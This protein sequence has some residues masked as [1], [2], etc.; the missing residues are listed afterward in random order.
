MDNANP[1]FGP[2]PY[3]PAIGISVVKKA[4]ARPAKIID[5]SLNESS[6]GASSLAT[7]KTQERCERLFR[8]PDPAS[9]VLRKAIG[10]AYDLNP[11]YLVCG[12]GSEELLDIIGR[13][14]ARP[15]DE[16]LFSQNSFMQ[17]PIVAMRVGA[18]VVT[19]SEENLTTVVDT[20][21]AKVTDKTKSF[22][23]RTRT[24]RPAPIFLKTRCA[25]FAINYQPM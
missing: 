5:L 8:Y 12:N 24:T 10:A 21:L 20:L 18:K 3:M 7:V 11:D 25:E 2:V 14:Y 16:I 17:F 13:L 1:Q 4:G 6:F 19:S 9:T 23:W 22:S 15:G